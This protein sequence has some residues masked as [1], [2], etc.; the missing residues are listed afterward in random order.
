MND[1]KKIIGTE[2]QND[3]F[4]NVL[5]KNVGSKSSLMQVL[6]DVQKIYGFIPECTV[7]KISKSL[8]VPEAEIFGVITFYSQFSLVPKAKYNIDVCLGT[9]CYVLG[10]SD[11]LNKICD[12]LKLKPGEVGADGKWLI[13]SCRCLGCCGLAPV[14]SINDEVY[15]KVKVEDIE[16]ILKNFN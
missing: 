14:L 12:V 9:A 3:K 15:G 5:V 4:E 7:V 11:V 16:N 10:A 2:E 13:S 8:G 6:Q 1:C